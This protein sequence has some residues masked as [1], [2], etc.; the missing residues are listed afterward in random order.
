M[1]FIN[2]SGNCLTRV[3]LPSI[4]YNLPKEP[5]SA[6]ELMPSKEEARAVRS[7]LRREYVWKRHFGA[8][9]SAIACSGVGHALL[10]GAILWSVW[11][12]EDQPLTLVQ[13]AEAP[14]VRTK[15]VF[16][17]KEKK[18]EKEEVQEA[19]TKPL[20]EQKSVKQLASR[21]SPP[22]VTPKKKPLRKRAPL[23]KRKRVRKIAAA[24]S[25]KGTEPVVKAEP[26]MVEV[27]SAPMLD[28]SPTEPTV[29]AKVPVE[30]VVDEPSTVPQPSINLD[31]IYA[32][33][34]ATVHGS[35][36]RR[37]HYPRKADRAGLEGT[38]VV[39]VVID[40]Q[41]NVVKRSLITSSGHRILDN[42]ALRSVKTISR[43]PA[44]PS[45][46]KWSRRAIRVPFVYRARTNAD[47]GGGWG[48]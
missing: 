35:F 26:K 18:P 48:S 6:P 7:G 17:E 23:A 29:V 37:S 15:F 16:T 25:S 46:L 13:V 27:E 1:I 20:V 43:L 38:V 31:A 3:I 5:P 24:P 34:R 39:E 2:I 12:A 21:P 30:E 44:P 4:T 40:A 10:I 32:S 36:K 14:P 19:K 22:K 9:L 41:G 47:A 11:S 33:Y 45:E 28:D 8:S 42:A